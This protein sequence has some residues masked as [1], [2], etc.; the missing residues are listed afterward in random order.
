MGKIVNRD[1]SNLITE[2]GN[3][4]K[5]FYAF[6]DIPFIQRFHISLLQFCSKQF[7][8]MGDWMWNLAVWYF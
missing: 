4:K 5:S 6:S 7:Q 8:L 3:F 1:L 2:Q